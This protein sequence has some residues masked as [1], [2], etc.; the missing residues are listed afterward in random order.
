MELGTIS[1]ELVLLI[2]SRVNDMPALS[3]PTPNSFE[4][5]LLL[6]VPVAVILTIPDE[7]LV[8]I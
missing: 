8:R 3:S 1:S 2:R 5:T 4:G 7:L 6:V